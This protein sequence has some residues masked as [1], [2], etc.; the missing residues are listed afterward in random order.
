[1]NVA[2]SGKKELQPGKNTNCEAKLN[3]R[4]ENPVAEKAEKKKDKEQFP[5]WLKINFVH[6][7]SLQRA[8]FLKYRSVGEDTKAAFSDMF[9][10]GFTPSAAH[11]EM[12]KHIK[13]ELQ[14]L[15]QKSLLTE[16][17]CPVSFG[18]TTG[19]DSG[20][21]RLLVVEMVWM[22]WRRLFI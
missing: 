15:G 8:E 16:A 1:M 22:P 11:A 2:S 17:S 13:A 5:L 12:R 20:L 21:T 7:H 10:Q 14:I 19:T 18:H 6:N 4:L 9:E 3:F